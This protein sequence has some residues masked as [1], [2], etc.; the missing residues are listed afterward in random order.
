MVYRAGLLSLL[1]L[2]LLLAVHSSGSANPKNP[3]QAAQQAAKQQQKAA[4]QAAKQQQ[5]AAQQ[6]AKQ[7]QQANQAQVHATM[8]NELHQINMVLGQA[9][10]DYDGFRQGHEPHPPGHAGTAQ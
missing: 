2:G 7:Q 1:S 3:Q 4:Q 5:K 10:H 9:K 8:I 6:A